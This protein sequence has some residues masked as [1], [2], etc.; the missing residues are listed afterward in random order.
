MLE[1]YFVFI[2][3]GSFKNMI[4]DYVNEQCPNSDSTN[5]LSKVFHLP[6]LIRFDN[7]A[8][9]DFLPYKKQTCHN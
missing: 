1:L 5:V 7:I 4:Y 2:T 6:E 3:W 8:E 9:A